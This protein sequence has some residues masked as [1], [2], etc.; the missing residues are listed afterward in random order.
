MTNILYYEH[1]GQKLSPQDKFIFSMRSHD[2]MSW[3][4][5]VKIAPLN[6]GRDRAAEAP[7][8]PYLRHSLF[9]LPSACHWCCFSSCIIQVDLLTLTAGDLFGEVYCLCGVNDDSVLQ[10]PEGP[11][12][13]SCPWLGWNGERCRKQWL[14]C[15][16]AA[17]WLFEIQSI[18]AV[19]SFA[20]HAQ[21]LF[22]DR[23]FLVLEENRKK[24]EKYPW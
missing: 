22:L 18:T 24:E 5:P 23:Q 7:S 13:G 19:S 10:S 12:P 21:G 15:L 16:H 8:H 17:W 2:T 6:R 3:M 20:S 1:V 4:E 14:N 11:F 9:S